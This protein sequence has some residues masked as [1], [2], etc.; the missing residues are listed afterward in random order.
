MMNKGTGYCGLVC[1]LCQDD[2]D[3]V[4][5]KNGG[6]KDKE[7]CK[8]YQCCQQNSYQGCYECSLFPCQDSILHKL[9]IRT[10]C[11]FVKEYGEKEL[12]SCLKNNEKA[13]IYY[14]KNQSH[15]GDYDVFDNEQDIID[16][17]LQGKVHIRECQLD[18]YQN[19]YDLN[20]N[21]MGYDYPLLLTRDKL[22]NRL[23]SGHDK[24]FVAVVHDQVIGYVHAC[25]YDVIYMD[26]LKNIMGIAVSKEYQHQG[27]GR[28]LLN[29]VEKW[30]KETNAA[31][32]RLVSGE[33]RSGAHQFYQACG[34][35]SHKKQLN[36]MKLFNDDIE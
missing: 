15:Y 25:D 3:C 31:G 34:Y 11:R 10:F 12:I 23:K 4:G 30:A 14:H 13:G 20:K 33:T 6:C 18:D 26:H 35:S 21:E 27:I 8:N 24:I 22:Q 36:F 19:I 16:L 32:V 29:A 17:I 28:K 2:K 5:C 1:E 7:K 9:R